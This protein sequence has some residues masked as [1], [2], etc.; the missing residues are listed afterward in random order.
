MEDGNKNSNGYCNTAQ[1][2]NLIPDSPL[3]HHAN[4][5]IEQYAV[6]P[7]DWKVL[8]L[9][10]IFS[11]F[12]PP[13]WTVVHCLNRDPYLHKTPQNATSERYKVNAIDTAT[14]GLVY[15][16]MVSVVERILVRGVMEHASSHPRRPTTG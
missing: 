6:V 4:L 8:H 2:H 15:V 5:G 1:T 10:S 13:F 16:V 3:K 12:D 14:A 11:T 9:S 7:R